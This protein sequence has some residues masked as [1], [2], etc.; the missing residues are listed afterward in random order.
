MKKIWIIGGVIALVIVLWGVSSYNSMI[1]AKR[2]IDGAWGQVQVVLQRRL[3]LVQQQMGSLKG[4]MNFEKSTLLAIVEARSGL[5]SAAASGNKDAQIAAAQKADTVMTQFRVQVEQYPQLGS[6]AAFLAFNADI[7]GNENRIAVERKRYNDA[8]T[9][10]N[11]QIV[12][13]PRM[14]LARL[15][16]FMPEKQFGADVAAQKAPVIDFNQK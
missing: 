2:G 16:G 9:D 8:V 15:F 4:E 13:F 1:T 10:Y 5:T 7:A 12:Q 14:I 3:D 6:N 11:I